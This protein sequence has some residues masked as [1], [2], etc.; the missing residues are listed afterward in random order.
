M[1]KDIDLQN[2]LE[3]SI[4]TLDERKRKMLNMYFIDK[5][6]YKEVGEVF[7]VSE[8]RAY[9]IVNSALSQLRKQLEKQG[10]SRAS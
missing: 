6:N 9:Q 3:K 8:S 10:I 7:G 4:E 1:K 5:L 2:I